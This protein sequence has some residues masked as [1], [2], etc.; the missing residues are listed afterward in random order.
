[1]ST[2]DFWFLSAN[3]YVAAS[4][5]AEGRS[6]TAPLVIAVLLTIGGFTASYLGK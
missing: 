2:A 4:M 6:K 3:I 1:M 5:A